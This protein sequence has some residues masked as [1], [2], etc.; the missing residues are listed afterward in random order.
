MIPW[1]TIETTHAEAYNTGELSAAEYGELVVST[2][3]SQR[4]EPDVDVSPET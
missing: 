3:E 4:Y 2:I 1:T